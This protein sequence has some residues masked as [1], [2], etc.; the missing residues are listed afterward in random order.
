LGSIGKAYHKYHRVSKKRELRI[1]MLGK[2]YV[3]NMR[4]NIEGVEF[5]DKS[6][7][8]VHHCCWIRSKMFNGTG[9]DFGEGCTDVVH[10]LHHKIATSTPLGPCKLVSLNIT[11]LYMRLRYRVRSVN[12]KTSVFG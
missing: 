5:I 2:C 10:Y 12:T 3:S 4:Y 9:D 8:S 6:G 7:T 1:E 11:S